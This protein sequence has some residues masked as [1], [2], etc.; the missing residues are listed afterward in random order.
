M[1]KTLRN[2]LRGGFFHLYKK[3]LPMIG[4]VTIDFERP[5]NLFN[6]NQPRHLMSKRHLRQAQSEC[7]RPS[8]FLAQAECPAY[9]ERQITNAC[10]CQLGD[11]L[12][13]SL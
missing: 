1:K 13:E 9:C 11:L 3:F 7:R 6:E 8:K 10:Q 12:S 5:I 4:F 2:N